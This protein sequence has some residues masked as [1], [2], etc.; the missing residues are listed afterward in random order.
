VKKNITIPETLI[1]FHYIWYFRAQRKRDAG[2]IREYKLM[3]RN[4]ERISWQHKDKL[5]NVQKEL[6]EL[7]E[8]L[9]ILKRYLFVK[10]S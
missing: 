10:K 2:K 3:L 9:N 1:N 6:K 5:N 4:E 7:R 8:E